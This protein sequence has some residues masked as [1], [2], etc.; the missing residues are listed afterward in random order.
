[1]AENNTVILR[2]ELDEAGTEKKLQQL[3]LDIESTKKAQAA[4]TAERK[5]GTVS[6][7]EFAKRSVELQTQLKGQQ[8]T[9]TALTKNLEAF[10]A[11]TGRATGSVDQLKAQAA[12]L[13][14]QYNALSKEEREN[15]Y[16]GRELTAQLDAA[17]KALLEAGQRVNDNRRN[18]GNYTGSLRDAIKESGF[19]GGVTAKVTEAQETFSKAQVIAKAAIGGNITALGFLRLALL[20]T[21][22]GAL[23]V[24][25]GSVV[26]FLTKSQAGVDLVSRK[27]AG[28]KA[29]VSLVIGV[30][31]EF[32][33]TL[34]KAFDNPKQ[35]L[36]DLVDF[37]GTN[38]LNR[39]KSLKVIFDGI[40]SGN[41][42]RVSE[43]LFQLSTGLT[44]VTGKV[45]RF[46]AAARE[47]AK[48]GES[49]EAESQ[50][51]LRAE[52][53][54]NVERSQSRARIE[55]L[56]KLSDDSTKSVAIR[57]AAAKEAAKIENGLLAQQ[58]KLQDDK[59]NNTIREANLDK[60]QTNDELDAI[61]ELRSARADTQQESLTL[62]TE[63][64]NKINS[65]NQEGIDKSIAGRAQAL[66]LQKA[67]LDEQ[68]AQVEANSL[69]ELRLLRAKLENGY[70][71]EL[72]VKDLTVSAKRAIDIKYEADRRKLE[73]DATKARALAMY[74]AE[75]AAVNTE[76]GLVQKG[77]DQETELRREAIDTQ[78]RKE[79][80][81][82]DQR[83][84]NLAQENLLRANAANALND[85]NYDTALAKLDGFLSAQ[86]SVL[87]ESF[88]AARITEK[89]YADSVIVSDQ[90]AA[91]ARLQLAR[92]FKKDTVQLEAQ[93]AAAKIAGIKQVGDAEREEQAKRMAQAQILAEG[94][95]SLFAETV[96]TTG[97]TLEDFAR[98]ALI[99]LIDSVEKEIITAQI[100]I[101][102]KAFASADSIATFGASGAIKAAA[103]IGLTVAATETLKAKL[104]PTPNQFAQ[105][106]VLGG[107]SHANGGVQL[108]SRSGYHF[109][110]AEADEIILTKGVF[111]SPVLRPLAST[112]NVLGGGRA[113]VPSQPSAHMALGGIAKPLVM[114]QLRGGVGEG[115]DYSRLAQAVSKINVKATISDVD[116][117]LK[118]KAFTDKVANS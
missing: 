103:I 58:L 71:A 56:K 39:L 63:L 21:G 65:L 113:L 116:A 93:A 83:K 88:A 9:Q 107:A 35:A 24:V 19:F 109:G 118:R 44:D 15:T 14:A 87:D 42:S 30:A 90:L 84:N 28:L 62:Q 45:S 69:E 59:I 5:A 25:L 98:K 26:A 52:R 66:A 40:T 22:L 114:Q 96:S 82:L 46:A 57:T 101:I 47:A 37:I 94:L 53:A 72:N 12:L 104:Q 17:N 49:I 80:A 70:Q 74:D 33:E 79:L 95:T 36:S 3:V 106:T 68:L 97:A 86:R 48:A 31:S 7:E 105:G 55:E 61:A 81:A 54:L 76:L 27:L 85:L 16:A 108:Y 38:L 117:G 73:V 32:G 51:I 64:Q 4:L 8:Q 112:L 75:L 23:V 115:I 91:G 77:T 78:L 13:T 34:F 60:Q 89:Q 20:A 10:R 100:A 29:I 11:A 99:L 43:G 1:M 50:R 92:E 111:Q 6:D 2:V 41:I 67:L 110:E 18:V 102:A